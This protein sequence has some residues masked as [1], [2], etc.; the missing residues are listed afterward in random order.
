MT[1]QTETQTQPQTPPAQN[2]IPTLVRNAFNAA[3]QRAAGRSDQVAAAIAALRKL[4]RVLL[5]QA[6]TNIA[7][8][9][10]DGPVS[11]FIMERNMRAF[12]ATEEAPVAAPLPPALTLAGPA[13]ALMLDAVDNGLILHRFLPGNTAILLMVPE[14]MGCL[15]DALGGTPEA[16]RLLDILRKGMDED[17]PRLAIEGPVSQRLH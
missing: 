6:G 15:C 7:L 10:V 9:V 11:G 14:L 4:R 13:A 5:D 1:T 8:Q 16:G 3:G 17:E 2:P 12:A